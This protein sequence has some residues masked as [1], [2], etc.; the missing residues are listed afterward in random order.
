MELPGTESSHF[1]LPCSSCRIPGVQDTNP[2]GKRDKFG[3]RLNLHL[4]H[5]PV[6]MSFDGAFGRAQFVG[7]MLVGLAANDKFENL[8][9]ARRQRR[10]MCAND[11]ELALCIA[12]A[13]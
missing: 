6:A 10:D 1:A 5:H 3:Q 12:C 9:L 2:F 7:D 13:S 8:A 11:V 4:L